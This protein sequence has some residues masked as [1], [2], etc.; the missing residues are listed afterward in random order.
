LELSCALAGVRK[1]LFPNY[2][3]INSVL[4]CVSTFKIIIILIYDH[5]IMFFLINKWTN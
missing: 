5:L 2:E 1:E 4:W 3:V